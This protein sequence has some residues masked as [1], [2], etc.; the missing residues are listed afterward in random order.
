MMMLVLI[1]INFLLAS[2]WKEK[3]FLKKLK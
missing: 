3:A 2:K 1:V